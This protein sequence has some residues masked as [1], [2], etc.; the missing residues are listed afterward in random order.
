MQTCKHHIIRLAVQM[1]HFI[2]SCSSENWFEYNQWSGS[3]TV[4]GLNKKMS[5]LECRWLWMKVVVFFMDREAETIEQR[6]CCLLCMQMMGVWAPIAPPGVMIS[7]HLWVCLSP[8]HPCTHRPY[9]HKHC[10]DTRASSNHHFTP[11]V[12]YKYLL[13][14]MAQPALYVLSVS[15]LSCLSLFLTISHSFSFQLYLL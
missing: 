13:E 1:V 12:S 6:V 10:L 15:E 3:H 11:Q 8:T 5:W 4:L 9:T 14:N 2:V 7:E